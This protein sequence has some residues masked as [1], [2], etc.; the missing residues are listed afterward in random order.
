MWRN[1]RLRLGIVLGIAV[2]AAF[3]A[4]RTNQAETRKP[5]CEPGRHEEKDASGKVIKVTRTTCFE[6]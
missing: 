4:W 3:V 2:I 1:R 5:P 6:K